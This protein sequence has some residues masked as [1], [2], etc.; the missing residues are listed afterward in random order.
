MTPLVCT[1]ERKKQGEQDQGPL[2]LGA[3]VKQRES[4]A[5]GHKAPTLPLGGAYP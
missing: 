4:R 3:A 1:P 2:L 5:S